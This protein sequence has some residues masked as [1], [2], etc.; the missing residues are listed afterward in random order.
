[1]KKILTIGIT[2]HND[3]AFI[4]RCVDSVINSLHSSEDVEIIISNNNSSDKTEC[5][6]LEYEKNYPNIK[7]VSTDKAG[8]SVAR[9]AVLENM[10][11][12]YVTFIDG[13]DYVEDGMFKLLDVLRDYNDVDLFHLTYKI[14]KP[15]KT[16]K[17]I[18]CGSEFFNKKLDRGE[19][20]KI[21]NQNTAFS[22]SS[23]KIIKASIIRD[24]MLKYNEDH[25]QMED[26]E[27][28]IKV[29]GSINTAMILDFSYYVYEV[30]HTGSLTNKISIQRMCQGLDAS[31]KSYD[32]VEG[33]VDDRFTQKQLK[34]FI[35]LM[36]YSLI[37]RYNELDKEGKRSF[38]ELLNK[39]KKIISYPNCIATKLFYIVYRLFG[40]DFAC[41]FV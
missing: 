40:L 41:K 21:L 13:D 4:N 7:V 1:M 29:W 10:H 9:N 38:R 6:A 2:V 30:L 26:M 18:C 5:L 16:F 28:G 35:G 11:G 25:F 23:C 14:I 22:S 27:F 17:P 24:N 34:Q 3:E 36:N 8:P 12:D 39:N 19:F 37:R 20:L 15:Q 32:W 31:V 33:N